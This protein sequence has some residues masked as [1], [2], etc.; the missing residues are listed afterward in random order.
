V[1][2]GQKV[3][4]LPWLKLSSIGVGTYMGADDD[5]TDEQVVS[6]TLLSV[7]RGVNVID[8]ARNYRCAGALDRKALLMRGSIY[9]LTRHCP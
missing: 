3:R 5:D 4:G 2:A 6:A 7:A 8:T 1:L 9:A